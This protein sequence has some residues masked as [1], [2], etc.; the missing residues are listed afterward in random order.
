MKTKN[1][2]ILA[3][4][5]PGRIGLVAAISHFLAERG[6]NIIEMNQFDD[7][8]TRR[9]FSRIQFTSVDLSLDQLKEQFT[10]VSSRFEMQA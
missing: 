7:L 9:F 4:Q 8:T 1:D 2:F 3:V 5:C 6:C 10:E